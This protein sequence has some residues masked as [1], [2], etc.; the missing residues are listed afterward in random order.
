MN[1]SQ[2]QRQP[3]LMGVQ[4]LEGGAAPVH[5]HIWTTSCALLSGSAWVG[6]LQGRG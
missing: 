4:T 5:Q 6:A 2:H 3:S 1:A